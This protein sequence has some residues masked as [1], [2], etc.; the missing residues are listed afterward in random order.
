[1]VAKAVVVV[2]G[3]DAAMVPGVPWDCLH[4]ICSADTQ[5]TQ[6]VRVQN[7]FCHNGPTLLTP[8]PWL[9]E[10]GHTS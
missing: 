6:A 7:A 5:D 1:M 3:V 8:R 10:L 4:A 2:C 9:L